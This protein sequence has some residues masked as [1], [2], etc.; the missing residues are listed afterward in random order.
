[1]ASRRASSDSRS[2]SRNDDTPSAFAACSH[3]LRRSA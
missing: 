2:T 3:W 1:M